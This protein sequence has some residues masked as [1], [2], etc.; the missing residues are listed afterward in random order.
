MKKLRETLSV[1]VLPIFVIMALLAPAYVTHRVD[2]I[3][4]EV[5]CQS[6]RANNVQLRALDS[7][8]K[9]LGIPHNFPTTPLPPE[10]AE[11]P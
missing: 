10:C 3:Q 6:A 4:F 2:D 1:V 7:I 11:Q 8:A 9:E 5:Q